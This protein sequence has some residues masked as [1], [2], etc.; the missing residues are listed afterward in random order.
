MSA[1]L[2]RNIEA[3]QR[4]LEGLKALSMFQ[5]MRLK[6]ACSLEANIEGLPHLKTRG[7]RFND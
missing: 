1:K 5:E 2:R 7:G 3:A 4:F 6:R